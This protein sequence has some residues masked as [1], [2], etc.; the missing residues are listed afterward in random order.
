MAFPRLRP[1]HRNGHG[2]PAGPPRPGV[3]SGIS[4]L[5]VIGPLDDRRSVLRE[6]L[7]TLFVRCPPAARRLGLA[8]EQAAIAARHRRVPEA[9]APHLAASRA[10]ILEGAARCPAKRRALIIGAGDCLDVPVE[11]LAARFEQVVLADVAVGLV[12]RRWARRFPRR[13][14]A[15]QWDATGALVA[16]AKQRQALDRAAAVRLLANADPGPPPGGEPDLVVSANCLS[17]LGLVPGHSLRAAEKDDDLPKRT[18]AAAAKR[19]WRWLGARPGVRVLLA[20]TAKL[21]LAPDGRVLKRESLSQDFGLPKPD[22]TWRWDLAPIPEWD[23]E[24][25]RVHEVGVWINGPGGD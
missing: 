6:F 22:R 12:A 16:L 25:H 14:Q 11:E 17:Q 9:W 20:D 8:H 3:E 1:R 2:A 19:H 24:Y 7:H 5:E 10:A 13:V 18:A 21:D 23:R 4:E 15:V